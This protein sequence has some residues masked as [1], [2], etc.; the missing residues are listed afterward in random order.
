VGAAIPI[1]ILVVDD[2]PLLRSL[3]CRVLQ[4][5]SDFRI[6]GEATT[7]A[8]AILKAK[9][10]KPDVIVIDIGLPD[11]DGLE[12]TRVIVDI[13]PCAEV[14]VV[15]AFCGDPTQDAFRAGASGYLLKSDCAK[16]L[17]IAVRTVN[18]FRRKVLTR[19]AS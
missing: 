13:A 1:R 7:G 11:M 19:I 8:E 10:L 12:V 9:E 18:N 14:I 6:V 2:H 15:S 5:E 16:D 3:I 4:A 17:A